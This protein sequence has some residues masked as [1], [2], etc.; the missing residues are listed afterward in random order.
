MTQHS[1]KSTEPGHW[2]LDQA[3]WNIMLVPTGLAVH[4]KMHHVLREI[5]PSAAKE[6][7]KT[8]TTKIA[9][10]KHPNQLSLKVA[11]YIFKYGTQAQVDIYVNSMWELT[12]Y[13]GCTYKYGGDMSIAV[14]NLVAPTCAIP[15]DVATDAGATV[16]HMWERHMEEH[17]N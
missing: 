9:G 12:N 2:T 7:D 17:V 1:L 11:G 14:K 13:T 16:C 3:Q 15:A 6:I 8:I 5:I 4:D 10:D